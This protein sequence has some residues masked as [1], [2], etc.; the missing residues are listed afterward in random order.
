MLLGCVAAR[1]GSGTQLQWDSRQM[2]T[3]NAL[4]NR[5]I[6]HEYRKG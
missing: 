3:N 2:K 1:V 4:A 6:Q 5:Y